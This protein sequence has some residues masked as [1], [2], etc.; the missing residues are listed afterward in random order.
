MLGL[1]TAALVGTT[2]SGWPVGLR[3]GATSVL[4]TMIGIALGWYRA[5]RGVEP[6]TRPGD[7]PREI[8]QLMR[9]Y[10]VGVATLAVVVIACCFLT[11]TWVAIAVTFVGVTAG[12]AVYEAGYQRAAQAVRER[13]A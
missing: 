1:W 3:I 9:A 2:L 8:A 6:S 4:V 12:L 7:A 13:L 5:K 10:Y 11:P